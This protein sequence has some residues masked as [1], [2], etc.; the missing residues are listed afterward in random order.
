MTSFLTQAD[1]AKVRELI[2]SYRPALAVID[3]FISVD[4]AVLVGPAVAGKDTLRESLLA[5]YP[6]DY[7]RVLSC[8]TRPAR[9]EESENTYKFV[10]LNEILELA[11]QKQ[12][13]QI[14][15][16]HNQQI[17]AIDKVEIDNL[18]SGKTGLS[19]LVIQTE[20]QLAKLKPDIKTIF[21]I[22]PS[23]EDLMSRLQSERS[24]DKDEIKRRLVAAK[25]EISLALKTPRYQCIISG[26][27]ENV[28]GIAHQFLW[29]GQFDDSADKRA[30][31]IM[32]SI[33]EQL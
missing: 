17:S 14:A 10:G 33:V 27:E 5:N 26:Q 20:Q 24:P 15:L 23:F 16:V 1:V 3:Q 28:E 30:R 7:Q 22:P 6:D 32:Q 13:L 11:R 9:V 18:S 31:Q 19:I 8:T 4:F 29:S 12:L 2:N 21:L 25:T